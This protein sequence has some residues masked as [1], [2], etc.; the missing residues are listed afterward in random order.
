VIL[1]G[2][3]QV[4]DRNLKKFKE[5]ELRDTA[6][7]VLLQ[8][9]EIARSP[10]DLRLT[11][12]MGT[13][14]T[15]RFKLG[16]VIGGNGNL[17]LIETTFAG[18]I[19]TCDE[20]S[21][22]RITTTDPNFVACNLITVTDVTSSADKTKGV[23]RV[24]EIKSEIAYILS[25]KQFT[26]ELITYRTEIVGQSDNSVGGPGPKGTVNPPPAPGSISF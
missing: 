19:T 15:K 9:L 12:L 17:Q 5:N 7:G 23:K 11:K 6:N 20:L 2:A 14:L 3:F 13:S 4:S 1:V 21:Q 8:S 24:F 22:I 25:E 10:I 26:D 18:G 16:S